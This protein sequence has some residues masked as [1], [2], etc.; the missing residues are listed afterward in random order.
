[1]IVV[2]RCSADTSSPIGS[3]A[4][5]AS[6]R[7]RNQSAKYRAEEQ[8]YA[9]TRR[10]A[11]QVILFRTRKRL[12]QKALARLVGTSDTAISRIESGT[13]LP[14]LKTLQRLADALGVELNVE[15]AER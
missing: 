1:M 10:I 15:L 6:Q 5:E 8:K 7:R 12:S 4:A 3:T 13:H 2:D 14:S 9:Q 11:E